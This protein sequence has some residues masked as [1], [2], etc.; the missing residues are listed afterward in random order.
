RCVANREPCIFE[1]DPAAF[2]GIERELFELRARQ[3]TIAPE[4][5][6]QELA[7]VAACGHS[8]RRQGLADH[9]CELAWRVG[10]AADR[11][12]RPRRLKGAAECGAGRQLARLDDDQR[13]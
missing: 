12:G 1:L 10:I 8:M 3:Q 2:A 4:M 13:L 5:L 6:D 9:R 7:G 11:D